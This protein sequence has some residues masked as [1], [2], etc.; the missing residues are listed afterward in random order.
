MQKQERLKDKDMVEAFSKALTSLPVI[1]CYFCK[2]LTARTPNHLFYY[3]R[4]KSATTTTNT[5]TT[6]SPIPVF[7]C[8]DCKVSSGKRHY[9]TKKYGL[10]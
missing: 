1:E 2:Q 9:Y 6:P 7:V 10:A 4:S 5:T 8:L 3:V